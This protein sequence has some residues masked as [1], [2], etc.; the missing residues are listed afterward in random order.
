MYALAADQD[1]PP[2]AESEIHDEGDE[3][4]CDEDNHEIEAI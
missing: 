2:V 1:A 3:H 4:S